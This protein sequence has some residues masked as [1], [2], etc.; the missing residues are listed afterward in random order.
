[1]T[2]EDCGEGFAHDGDIRCEPILPAEPCPF[3]QLAVPG[4]TACRPVMPC[5]S[6]KWGDLA[7][8]ATTQYVDASYAGGDSDGSAQ[9]PWT[10]IADAHDAAAPGALIALAE[11]SYG[12]DVVINKPVRLW[13]VCP[14]QVEIVG[15]SAS[16]AVLVWGAGDGSEVG[17]LAVRGPAIGVGIQ[18]VE[19]VVFDRIW[20][21]DTLDRGLALNSY[22]KS[23]SATLRDSL[24]ERTS[25]V[26]VFV[27]SAFEP[28]VATV[29]RTAIRDTA[30]RVSDDY[31]GRGI[32]ITTCDSED[33]CAT[34]V[35]AS[36]TIA[37]TLLER[38][39][40]LGIMINAADA[41]IENT[42]VRETMPN[43][44][45]L[46]GGRGI[47]IHP[48]GALDGCDEPVRSSAIV[49]GS[50]IADNHDTGL[51]IS[52]SDAHVER[53]R[54]T[55][56]EPQADDLTDGRGVNIQSPCWVDVDPVFCDPLQPSIATLDRVV[57]ENNHELGVWVMGSDMTMTSTV[58]RAT[59]PDA[60]THTG[61]GG[62]DIAPCGPVLECNPST[63]S[64]ATLRGSLVEQHHR[65]SLR[66]AGSEAII[67]STLVRDTD[68]TENDGIRGIGVM[69]QNPCWEG[70]G[71]DPQAPSRME[72]RASAIEQSHYVGLFV[73]DSDVLVENSVV[74]DVLPN[75]TTAPFGDGIA[76]L[77]ESGSTH[78]TIT[79]SLVDAT[80]RAG[81]SSFGGIVALDS[82]ALQC[83]AFP[84]TGQS[85]AGFDYAFED[86]GGNVCGCPLADA[87]CKVVNAAL[88]P[89][90]P[91]L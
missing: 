20:V 78:T 28:M 66:V 14:E 3:G 18:G 30:P 39:V 57:V 85:Y 17:G 25:D 71:C 70:M 45:L 69:V 32:D 86:R 87:A 64:R 51:F 80:A 22:S 89:P 6:G 5:G 76:V 88:E 82:N 24:V 59:L 33:G 31:F 38:N 37:G 84:L 26:A 62:V 60:A 35:R 81:V 56:T 55:G 46:N 49:R 41:V 75:A 16:A 61:G 73:T 63:G 77:S 7:V 4:D 27:W 1:M 58:V 52:G 29:E 65:Y 44:A 48:C 12:E 13:G 50:L 42:V 79:R 91:P 34:P 68:T 72:L 74:R 47:E 15:A 8:D 10:T 23:A 19:N 83:A 36:A 9:R 11:G 2:A 43:A 40:D 67:E 21:H 54:V 53:T 90:E